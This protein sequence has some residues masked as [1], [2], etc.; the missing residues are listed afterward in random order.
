M[1]RLYILL[2]LIFGSCISFAQ[3]VR[4]MDAGI[5]EINRE[6]MHSLPVDQMD[7]RSLDGVWKFLWRENADD[8]CPEGFFK[9]NFD[10]SA[11]DNMPV[12]GMW[13]LNGYGDPLYENTAYAWGNFWKNNP[14]Q[15]PL[16]RNHVGI[17]RR[18]VTVPQQW[19]GKDIFIHIGS[20]TSNVTLWVNGRE[21][22]YS[23]DSK[24]AA[25]FN[26]TKYV[27]PGR[28]NLITMEIYRWCDGTYLECQDFWRLSGTARE[29]CIFCREKARMADVKFT[30]DLSAD[31]KDGT[32]DVKVTTVGKVQKVSISLERENADAAPQVCTVP[33][34]GKVETSFTVRNA[35]LW[36][37]EDPCLYKL[38]VKALGTRDRVIE[39]FS[40]NAGFRKVEIRNA[41][42]L[43]NGKAILIKGADRHE[44]SPKGGYV[45]SKE[46]MIRDIQIMKQLNINAVRT[47]HYPNSPIWYDLCDQYGI[48][49]VDEGNIESHGMGYGKETL[50]ANPLFHEAHL[51]RDRRMVLRDYNHPSV[52]VWSLGNE[53]GNGQNF[54][55][56]YDW[57][58]D[59][60]RSRPVQ[61]ERALGNNPFDRNTDI[62]CPM[63]ATPEWCVD[64]C[65]N[66]PSKPLI[67]CEYAHAMG[68]SMGGFREYW[69]I[70]RKYP[71]YQGGFI[72]D[73]VD[74][75]LEWKDP[76]TGRITYRFGGDY[77]NRDISS[78]NFN[79]N[80]II[81]ANRDIHPC[82]WEVRHQ[83]Q[84]IWT[85]AVEGCPGKV[86]VFNENFFVTLD[87][88]IMRWSLLADGV[89][90][91]YGAVRTQ[92]IEPGKSTVID[93]GLKEKDIEKYKGKEL[94]VNLSY[95]LT[96]GTPLLEKGTEVAFDQLVLVPYDYAAAYGGG[97]GNCTAQGGKGAALTVND[98]TVT[99]KGFCVAFND[100][101]WMAKYDAGNGN[102]LVS[103]VEPSF[104][105]A[106]VDNDNGIIDSG[107]LRQQS[108][109]AWRD[110]K[111]TNTF[112]T[113]WKE[114]DCVKV[115]AEYNCKRLG[116][117]LS[118]LYTITPD[119]LVR[120][121]ESMHAGKGKNNTLVNMLRFG[122]HFD[123]CGDYSDIEFYGPGPQETYSD[124]LS[125]YP[126]GVYSQKVKDQFYPWYSACGESGTHSALRW[127]SIRTGKGD[128][129]LIRSAGEFSACA[130][131][132]PQEQID[133]FSQSYRRHPSELEADG[134]VHVN[135]DYLQQ[136]V[137]CINSWG[138]F[139]LPEYMIPYKDYSWEFEIS[140]L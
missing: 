39:E 108:F 8:P 52:I 105:R 112:F 125:G 82:T 71:A 123:L 6:P 21:V 54:M 29:C 132:F 87:N 7:S 89:Q 10:D 18:T 33:S 70:I 15:V 50:A 128:G 24:L 81:A 73:F 90:V 86:K 114:D 63:Y 109:L 23:Q 46:E 140:P 20:A 97:M 103:P 1:K 91:R 17:Y 102:I 129:I 117:K 62:V 31:Y 77:N 37:A 137:G 28:E 121:S 3:A 14:P 36:S 9:T 135:V 42:L 59:Y 92:G 34:S 35:R 120:I 45:V 80:G 48:Y 69:D 44:M 60:D 47:S 25:E 58:K 139:P 30:P 101:G 127:W 113:L 96:E 13:E 124:R 136:G 53:A 95:C 74:Q 116:T 83:Y 104:Y 43:V 88:I 131:P 111:W 79:C 65:L 57:I 19:K 99:G 115:K 55:D 76:A 93:L 51:E 122:M 72:W 68:N 119:G 22:G 61:Y 85:S 100:N 4:W 110:V 78:G 40:F 27:V 38:T 2:S 134:A 26:I 94:I 107:N 49:V 32:L 118:F 41:Q 126:V 84:N 64:Y 138:R 12:P 5:F 75:A 56:C 133:R 16:E 98:R 66:N 67:Q 11:W 106:P 130:I